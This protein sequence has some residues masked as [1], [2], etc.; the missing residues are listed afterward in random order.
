MTTHP[1]A[2]LVPDTNT[3]ECVFDGI[4]YAK[5]A[6]T[7]RQLFSL[8]SVDLFSKA[9]HEYFNKFAFGNATLSD[10]INTVDD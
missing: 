5:G 8:V 3:A 6:A 4:T 2:G 10:F 1:I 7:I 9:M